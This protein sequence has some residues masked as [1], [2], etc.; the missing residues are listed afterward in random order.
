MAVARRMHACAS[1][2]DCNVAMTFARNC[3]QCAGLH[4]SIAAGKPQREESVDDLSRGNQQ[5]CARCYRWPRQAPVSRNPRGR[6]RFPNRQITIF[7]GLAAGGG[8]DLIT[9]HYASKLQDMSGQTVVVVNRPGAGGNLGAAAAANQ[10]P[11]A[12]RCWS[13]RTSRSSAISISTRTCRITRS[14][15]SRRSRRSRACRS[16]SRCR[17]IRRS[18]R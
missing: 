17:R 11:T 14:R 2:H 9:R 16:S 18:T 13:R 15:A 7:S 3:P 4:T 5:A 12:T 10:S 8:A 6:R 1:T